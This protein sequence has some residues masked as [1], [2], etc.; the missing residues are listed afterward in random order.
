VRRI[1]ARPRPISSPH[2]GP[3]GRLAAE[4]GEAIT[5]LT[6]PERLSGGWWQGEV[7]REY[8]FAHTVHGDLL[9][10]FYD[11]HRGQWF[12]QGWVE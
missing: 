4:S 11:C 3:G 12:Q 2:H 6:G 1:L 10:L 5:H 7:D 8:W 9:W